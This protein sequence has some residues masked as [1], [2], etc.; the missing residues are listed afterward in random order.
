[1]TLRANSSRTA[2]ALIL[3]A[4]AVVAACANHGELPQTSSATSSSLAGD[5][6]ANWPVQAEQFRFHWSASSGIDLTTGP[7]VALRAYIESYLLVRIAD[8]ESAVYPGFADATPENVSEHD[9]P[10]RQ[11]ELADVRPSP[12]TT[13]SADRGKRITAGYQPTHVLRLEPR[14]GSYRATVCLGLYSVY[15]TIKNKPD[16]YISVLA[17]STTGQ[18]MYAAEG[19]PYEGGIDVWTVELTD[20]DPRR[21]S[22]P[23]PIGP[24]VGP[25]PAPMANVFGNWFITGRSSGLWGLLGAA[26]DV[27]TPEMRKQCAD[28]MPDDASTRDAIAK[29]FTRSRRPTVTRSLVGPKDPIDKGE[30]VL[31]QSLHRRTMSLVTGR[32]PALSTA[33]ASRAHRLPSGPLSIK[34]TKLASIRQPTIPHDALFS[35]QAIT[36]G[37]TSRH[38][39][40]YPDGQ[41][42]V[43]EFE[44][45]SIPSMPRGNR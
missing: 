39:L 15:Q 5:G 42:A 9:D 30:T 3:A 21:V 17:D 31:G 27:A 35:P 23:A 4:G 16:T 45:L 22:Q 33:S 8:N 10:N 1:M 11:L 32:S 24:Q 37:A 12:Q 41:R 36:R 43:R 44:R 2:A 34:T 18:A 40:R 6:Y 20:K 13:D 26:E 29:G 28:A 19:R 7:T 25:L 38:R 14:G